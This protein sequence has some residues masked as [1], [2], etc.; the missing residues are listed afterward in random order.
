MPA[1]PT[2][3]AAARLA[4]LDGWHQYRHPGRIC[5]A[6][7]GSCGGDPVPA[8]ARA[9]AAHDS[10]GGARFQGPRV[11]RRGADPPAGRRPGASAPRSG[12][13]RRSQSLPDGGILRVHGNGRPVIRRYASM[14][15]SGSVSRSL[16]A[17]LA[18]YESWARTADRSAR[19]APARAALNA[20]RQAR[21]RLGPRATPRQVAEAA[22]SARKAHYLRLSLAGVAARR[23]RTSG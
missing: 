9:W 2:G 15:A 4:G 6:R 16:T 5:K 14:T 7:P 21:E 19:T 12:G 20:D 23:R 22:A 11:G 13:C 18:A 10:V 17:R 3:R 8:P 1:G